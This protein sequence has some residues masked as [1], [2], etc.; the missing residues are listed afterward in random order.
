MPR[1]DSKHDQIEKASLSHAAM[2]TVIRQQQRVGLRLDQPRVRGGHAVGGVARVRVRSLADIGVRRGVAPL[3]RDVVVVLGDHVVI[4]PS[5][6]VAAGREPE[7][8]ARPATGDCK[9]SAAHQHRLRPHAPQRRR[10]EARPSP[11]AAAAVRLPQVPPAASADVQPIARHESEER[12]QPPI[13]QLDERRLAPVRND[14]AG[15]LRRMQP[16]C[17]RY[18]GVSRSFHRWRHRGSLVDAAAPRPRQSILGSEVVCANI[19]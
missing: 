12:K 11:T 5:C 14:I 6:A 18:R 4:F 7:P 15:I 1:L 13:A 2:P 17:Q 9:H 19:G 8:D 3:R 16:R 10:R